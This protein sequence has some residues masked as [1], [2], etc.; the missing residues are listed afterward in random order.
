MRGL[1]RCCCRIVTDAAQPVELRRQTVKSLAQGQSGIQALLKLAKDGKFPD[2]LRFTATQA[3]AAV[4][5]PKLKEQIAK[6]FPSPNALGGQTLPPI[7]ELVKKQGDAEH[8][9]ELFTKESTSCI[10]C[11]RIGPVRRGLRSGAF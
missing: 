3:L 11:H 1:C 6:L 4:Q 9:K 5:L 2:D 7:S 10:T 8:G